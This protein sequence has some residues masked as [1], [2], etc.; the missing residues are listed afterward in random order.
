MNE[1]DGISLPS[2]A[3][4]YEVSL[5]ICPRVYLRRRREICRLTAT[6]V[7]GGQRAEGSTVEEPEQ[8]SSD[9]TTVIFRA[10]LR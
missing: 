5:L 9:R 6:G 10:H 2:W 3:F 7:A 4:V 1:R 8:L